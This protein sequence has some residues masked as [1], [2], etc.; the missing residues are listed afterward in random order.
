MIVLG[1]YVWEY[2][3]CS[4]AYHDLSRLSPSAG[5]LAQEIAKLM[6]SILKAFKIK[7]VDTSKA[8]CPVKVSPHTLEDCAQKFDP[9]KYILLA[10]K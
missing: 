8:V 1:I 9:P 3:E 5:E 2:L 10:K 4:E 6:G 7:S